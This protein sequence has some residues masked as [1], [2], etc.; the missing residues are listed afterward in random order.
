MKSPQPGWTAEVVNSGQLASKEAWLPP[1]S[2]VRQTENDPWKIEPALALGVGSAHNRRVEMRP[3]GLDRIGAEM[4][5]YFA[6]RH[7]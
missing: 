3:S 7:P 6:G 5:T 2:C 1:Q 4:I